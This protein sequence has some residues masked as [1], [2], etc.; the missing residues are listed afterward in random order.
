MKIVL[1]DGPNLLQRAVHAAKSHGV[2][3][4]ADGVPTAALLI[5]INGLSRHVR[6]ERPHWMVVCWDG[7]SHPGRLALHPGY[8]LGR[9]SDHTDDGEDTEYGMAYRFLALANVQQV[10]YSGV[11][12]DDL[13]AAYWRMFS[14]LELTK[15][16]IVSGDR[17][18]HQLI[19]EHTEIALPNSDD[20]V[21]EES[22]F[23]KNGYRPLSHPDV[24]ALVG[25]PG[26]GVDGVPGIGP[27]RAKKLLAEHDWRMQ[28]LLAEHQDKRLFGHEDLVRRNLALVDLTCARWPLP[29]L[30]G[31]MRWNPTTIGSAAWLPLRSFLD[32]YQLAT[33]RSRVESGVLWRDD[34][35]AEG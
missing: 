6:A 13:I 14:A 33:V 30:P 23:A 32:Q 19:G 15:T 9:G 26:D 21:T 4:S 25:D 11:E 20:R 10:R 31:L 18:F 8:K 22:F 27:V 17:D 12:A 34:R 7:G 2:Q 5:F 3:L 35:P 28:L 1:V 16:V 24:M 29:Q